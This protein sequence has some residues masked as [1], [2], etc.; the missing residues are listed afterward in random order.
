[1]LPLFPPRPFW[2]TSP[3]CNWSNDISEGRI[4]LWGRLFRRTFNER[5]R[6]GGLSCTPDGRAN[7]SA[8][9]SR[10]RT[11][12]SRGS[13]AA[14]WLSRRRGSRP[15]SGSPASAARDLRDLRCCTSGT[16]LPSHDG[17]M[18]AARSIREWRLC[19]VVTW[20]LPP[21]LV[22]MFDF[23]GIVIIYF[24]AIILVFFSKQT[25]SKNV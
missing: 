2:E 23:C 10:P 20:Q 11:G 3:S 8:G 6:V 16:R 1:M 9:R 7:C 15:T 22:S 19:G 5:T 14:A 21:F 12:W 17:R 18:Y 4:Y 24:V 25:K 13:G